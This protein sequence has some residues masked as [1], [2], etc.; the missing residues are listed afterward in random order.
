MFTIGPDFT[1]LE[2]AVLRAIWVTHVA[3]RVALEVQLST[4]TL[5]SREN[6]GVGFYTNFTVGLPNEVIGGE[7]LRHGPAARIDGLERGMGFI[8]W[9]NE[10]HAN[11]LEGYTYDESTVDIALDRVA[12][13]IDP[14]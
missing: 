8:L 3:D 14:P 7:R 6:T 13:T 4:A 5:L 1:H 10:G 12:F 2:Q 9:L 11:S